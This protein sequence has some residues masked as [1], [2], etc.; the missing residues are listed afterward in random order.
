MNITIAIQGIKGSFHHIV[1]KQC[2]GKEV[3]V[4]ECMSFDKAVESLL[5]K[6]TNCTSFFILIQ[7]CFW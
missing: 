5:N 6:E 4:K 3:A 2:F 1:F 7:N